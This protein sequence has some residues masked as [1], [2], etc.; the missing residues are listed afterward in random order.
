MRNYK[1][2]PNYE[3]ILQKDHKKL[4]LQLKAKAHIMSFGFINHYL[5]KLYLHSFG[6]QNYF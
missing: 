5:K 4:Y 2:N 3:L 1:N 6:I